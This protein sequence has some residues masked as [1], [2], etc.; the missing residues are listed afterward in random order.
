MYTWIPT[1]KA[2]THIQEQNTLMIPVR[3]YACQAECRR[4]L[5]CDWYYTLTENVTHI[6]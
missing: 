2:A 6:T 1:R 4:L 5:D 3:R